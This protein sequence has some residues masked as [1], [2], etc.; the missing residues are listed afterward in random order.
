MEKIRFDVVGLYHWDVR[1]R[2]KEYAA[3]AV[4]KLLT[5]QPQPENPIDPY[6]VRA[7]EGS[8]HV[9]YVAVPDIDAVYQALKGSGRR[10]LKGI[11]VESNPEPP[12][13]TVECEVE[14]VDWTYEPFDDSVYAGWHYD[15]LPL[16]PKKLEQ[17]NDL[18]EDLI[19]ALETTP[20]NQGTGFE[21][22]ASN[23]GTGFVEGRTNRSLS[24]ADGVTNRD[25]VCGMTNRLLESNLYDMWCKMWIFGEKMRRAMDLDK[26]V[27]VPGRRNLMELLNDTFTL[28][29]LNTVRRAQGMKGDGTALL[30][31]WVQRGYCTLD[32][33]T[34]QYTKSPQFI[35]KHQKPT[36]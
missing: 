10:R 16:M 21:S 33:V 22:T 11:V 14:A 27:M 17:L 19:E 1:D 12:V 29:D 35:A 24:S 9:G 32:A 15:G 34:K 18:T 36:A 13:L 8:L 31:K 28:D 4:G 7:R 20:P 30:R 26:A 2:W 5:L 23:Q 6:A 25:A 3:E